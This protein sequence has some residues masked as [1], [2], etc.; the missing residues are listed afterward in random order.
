MEKKTNK[1]INIL[2][3]G[4]VFGKSGINIIKQMLPTLKEEHKIDFVIAQ[5]ENVS[6]RKGLEPKDYN[7]LKEIGI[8]VFTLGNHVWA[9]HKINEIIDNKDIVRPFNVDVGYPGSGTNIFDVNDLKIRVTSLLGI[10]FNPLNSPWKQKQANNFFD[11]IDEIIK[12]DDSDFHI[13]DFHAETTSEKNVLALYLDGKIS[14]LIGT[15][16]HIQTN[17]ARILENN[18]AYISDAGM[19]GPSNSAIGAN[20]QEV[21]EKMRFDKMISFK[22]SK[23]KPQFNGVVLKL[24][25]TRKS[26]II[27]ININ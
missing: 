22:P 26:Q 5:A 10:T 25:K 4:D 16:T 21:Y 13:V 6:G 9:K 18:L 3:I 27:P 17:D 11:A 2:F 20:F 1:E 23:N 24:S 19:T 7:K 14:A 8:N 15:H 12:Y